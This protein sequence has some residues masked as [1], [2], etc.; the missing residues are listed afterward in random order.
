MRLYKKKVLIVRGGVSGLSA[1]RLCLEHKAYVYI[2]DKKN[3]Q[4]ITDDKYI[5]LNCNHV[6]EE[7]IEKVVSFIDLIIVSPAIRKNSFIIEMANKYRK[8]VISEIELASHFCKKP[9]I[10]ITGTNG[11]T[12]LTK[13]CS[14]MLNYYGEKSEVFGN[15][16]RGFAQH[17]TRVN[18]SEISYVVLEVSA[19]HMEFTNELKP[20]ISVIT[21]IKPEHMDEYESFNIYKYDK[22]KIF[23]NQKQDDYAIFN[24]N[25]KNCVELAKR[26]NAK[27]LWFSY[28]E[29]IN[30]DGIYYKDSKIC[31]VNKKETY[32]YMSNVDKLIRQDFIEHCLILILISQ[33]VGIITIRDFVQNIDYSQFE[34]RLELVREINN[35]KYIND[36]KAT[37]PYCTMF[38]LDI[39]K[40]TVLIFGSNNQKKSDFSYLVESIIKNVKYTILIDE[41][42]IIVSEKLKEK[43]YERHCYVENLEDAI[44][45][46][47]RKAEKGD[48]I[49]FSPGGNSYPMF[50]NHVKRGKEF[51]KLVRR[52]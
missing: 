14:K 47:K 12:T 10:A 28:G 31:I 46:A 44:Q 8:R 42:G 38:A 18:L 4:E 19:Q 16:N 9:I 33:I 13:L 49:L 48:N 1:A 15:I 26:C 52:L 3:L 17:V 25:D 21:N 51:K 27:C 40:N 41:T 35:V 22:A 39:L 2:C 29:K 5:H 50:E 23:S 36:S 6:E 30:K 7:Q 43:N 24:Y 11:K 45:I 20:S 34:N 37:N 32:V